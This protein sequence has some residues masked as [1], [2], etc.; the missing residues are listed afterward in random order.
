MA[1]GKIKKISK[2]K[3]EGVLAFFG[4]DPV[5]DA[6]Q[7]SRFD[8][9]EEIETLITWA[10]DSDPKVSL[11]ALKHL[12]SV[13]R[14]VAQANGLFGTVQQTKSV[15]DQGQTLTS[16]VSTHTL[17]SNLTKENENEK[18]RTGYQVLEP[19]EA[20]ESKSKKSF[21]RGL[22]GSVARSGGDGTDE[23]DKNYDGDIEEL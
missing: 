4:M 5:S 10:R 11:P 20:T 19:I 3:D 18:N 14:E 9:Q 21:G 7:A 15:E 2:Q 1:N 6:I 12:R 8:V 16:T 23:L 13:L 22:G 17:L